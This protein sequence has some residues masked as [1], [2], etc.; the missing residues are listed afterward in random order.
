[1]A[2]SD[3]IAAKEIFKRIIKKG[4]FSPPFL[5][6]QKRLLAKK[7]KNKFITNAELIRFYHRSVK[8]RNIGKDE[9]LEK[10]LR[11]RK[12]RTMSGVAVI[13][14]LTKPFP[15]PG[16]CLYCP[17]EKGMPK[18]YL[19]NEP[20]ANRAYATNFDP[21]T[22]V[23]T[24]IHALQMNGHATDKIELIVLGGTW[25]AYPKNYQYWFTKECFRAANN[26]NSKSETYN[27]KLIF[28]KRQKSLKQEQKKN[29]TAKNRIVGLTLE[30]RPDFI[31]LKEIKQMRDLGCT[32]VELGVQSI[33]DDVLKKN[34]RGH[35]TAQT[36]SATRLLKDAGFKINY[37][38]MLNL[39]GSNPQRDLK[40]FKELFSSSDF[41]P[42]MLK[43]YPCVVLA[44][45]PLYKLWRT[46]GYKPYTERQLVNLLLQ[47][48][49]IIPPYVRI[50][51]I[52][53]DIPKESIFAGCQTSNLR[54]LID[55]SGKKICQCIRCRE[56]RG[57]YSLAD[58]IKLFRRDYA[59]SGG[60]EIFL[61]FES[62]DQKKLYALLRLRIPSVMF[63]HSC[64]SR[65]PGLRTGSRLKVGMTNGKDEI[66]PILHDSALIRELHTYGRLTPLGAKPNEKFS[67]HS[68][69]GKQLMAEAAKIAKDAGFKKIAVISGIGV[70]N[71]YKK[72][73]Y[74]LKNEYMIKE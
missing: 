67:Q 10:L 32:R 33:Y 25:S 46:G 36:I 58:K 48:K 52:I 38:I 24:R 6:K 53:R 55:D 26:P 13:T 15:C 2:S 49:K 64:E 9:R 41:Q 69:C 21:F 31:S 56:I 29:E 71:Y 39:P 7:Q 14:V 54:Q 18:S 57:E 11:R 51:R 4:D 45:A 37:H 8:N 72:L 22:Q 47:I 70:R 17:D 5:A 60:K 68:G 34:R 27:S 50:Q 23:K 16:R 1:M 3:F 19:K 59:A 66:F 43:I 73:G 62:P 74:R 65:N 12:I 20:A 63:C 35:K 28:A 40:M 42:D 44:S 30:T 61:S